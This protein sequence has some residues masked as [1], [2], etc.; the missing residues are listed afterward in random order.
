MKMWI[1]HCSYESF[2]VFYVG[3]YVHEYG[4]LGIRGTWAM[5]MTG[6]PATAAVR[7]CVLEPG[8]VC[9]AESR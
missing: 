2:L 4:V 3:M 5:E 1:F 6:I 9:G 8:I 7:Y